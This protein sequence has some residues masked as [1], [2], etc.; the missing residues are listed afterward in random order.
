[1]GTG[2]IVLDDDVW[3]LSV[4]LG[5]GD[6]EREDKG[7]ESISDG[8]R[9]AYSVV[10]VA[11]GAKVELESVPLLLGIGRTRASVVEAGTSIRSVDVEAGTSIRVVDVETGS[12]VAVADE[13]GAGSSELVTEETMEGTGAIELD[14]TGYPELDGAGASP[15]VSW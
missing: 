13:V 10:K 14:S 4:I 2:A 6:E 12:S 5:V 1:V 8:S 3:P 7:D 11:A 15:P 9:P